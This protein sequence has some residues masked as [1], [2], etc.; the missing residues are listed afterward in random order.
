VLPTA[1]AT[2]PIFTCMRLPFPEIS[3]A[4]VGRGSFARHSLRSSR[5]GDGSVPVSKRRA[6]C[7]PPAAFGVALCLIICALASAPIGSAAA[8]AA[9]V[10]PPHRIHGSFARA[11]S[12]TP[13]PGFV[14]TGESSGRGIAFA[15]ESGKQPAVFGEF[16]T[17]G[18]SLHFAFDSAIA[19]HARLM[20][21]IS[22]S[23]GIGARAVITPAGIADGSGDAFLLDLSAEIAQYGDPVYVRLLP[24]MNNAN[25]AYSGFNADGS[26]RGADYSP[27][28]FK[29]AWRRVVLILRGGRTSAIDRRL[30]TLGLPP[31]QGTT[32]A[33]IPRSAIAFVWTPETEGTP[34]VPQQAAAS[35]Y[36]GDQYVDWVGTDFYSRFPNFAGL[37]AFYAQYPTK[38]FVFA[39]WALWGDDSAAFVSQ[40]FAFV[41]GHRRVQM[42]LYND[43]GPFN[44]ADYPLARVAIRDSIFPSRFLAATGDPAATFLSPF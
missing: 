37:D 32:R 10:S 35:Y 4:L 28:T 23:P 34:N 5:F 21:H 26:A 14:Y 15:K 42:I 13:A 6:N 12:L 39:E 36:P 38:P 43:G 18:Q 8:R 27:E 19:D 20:L 17:W 22:T 31:I 25:N 11:R 2:A 29:Q 33:T 44:L 9:N 41:N 1:T 30:A 3:I 40:F 16:V 24:E 7:R